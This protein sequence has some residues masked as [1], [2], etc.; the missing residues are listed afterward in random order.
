MVSYYFDDMN[1]NQ[2]KEL[3][4]LMGTSVAT[5]EQWYLKLPFKKK[6][7]EQK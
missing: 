3:A 7:G 2:K 1:L 6:E 5:M 4:K